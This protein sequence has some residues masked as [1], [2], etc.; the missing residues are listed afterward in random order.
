MYIVWMLLIGLL[1]GTAAH[2]V[3]PGRAGGV[4]MTIA[5]GLAGSFLGGFF[6]RA[7]GFYRGAY[8]IPGIVASF[9]GALLFL[10][11]FRLI[12]GRRSRK[13]AAI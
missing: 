9:F 3:M 12:V 1:V 4:I 6:S 11:I 8:D 13:T 2:L 10:F 7:L 5:L